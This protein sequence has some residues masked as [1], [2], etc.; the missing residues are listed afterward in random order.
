MIKIWIPIITIVTH[1]FLHG[2][3]S[4]HVYK[5]PES[6]TSV[7]EGIQWWED[8]LDDLDFIFLPTTEI[9]IS[10]IPENICDETQ[11]I[12]LW[13]SLAITQDSDITIVLIPVGNDYLYCDGVRVNDYS[14][15]GI[16]YLADHGSDEWTHNAVVAHGIGHLAG[17]DHVDD[18]GIMD[19]SYYK[20]AY[21]DNNIGETTRTIIERY[22]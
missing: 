19:I 22:K 6:I 15:A 17:L 14:S 4:V 10:Y 18:H 3:V 11:R 13:Q 16:I 12:A 2:I 21:L 20:S 1:L 5:A 8:N 9:N 7:Q